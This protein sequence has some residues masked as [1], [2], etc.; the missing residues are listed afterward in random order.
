[1]EMEM[2]TT[3]R[4]ILKCPPLKFITIWL[5]LFR[6]VSNYLQKRKHKTWH[7]INYIALA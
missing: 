6:N 1:M 4:L 3:V 7:M 5:R 2:E